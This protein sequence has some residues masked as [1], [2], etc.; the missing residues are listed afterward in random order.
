[1][2]VCVVGDCGP[3]EISSNTLDQWRKERQDDLC[4]SS[5]E[6][7]RRLS[8]RGAQTCVT[9]VSLFPWTQLHRF[10]PAG[11]VCTSF[12]RRAT[13]RGSSKDE[14]KIRLSLS[15]ANEMRVEI[16]VWHRRDYFFRRSKFRLYGT[17]TLQQLSLCRSKV[18]QAL[19]SSSKD[20]PENLHHLFIWREIQKKSRRIGRSKVN[21]S[22]L[23]ITHR[24]TEV[25][26]LLCFLFYRL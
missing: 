12:G 21:K 3:S 11:P 19:E 4:K 13:T 2:C 20:Q 5:A 8:L 25:Y 16:G 7:N 15:P 14:G 24:R 17:A 22:Q 1:M 9:L 26:L 23:V 10:P 6:V 18:A